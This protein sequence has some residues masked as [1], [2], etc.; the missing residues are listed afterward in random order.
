MNRHFRDTVV[1]Q[2]TGP[3][4]RL[5]SGRG[6]AF[7]LAAAGAAML[8]TAAPGAIAP[9]HAV[10]CVSP[11]TTDTD[12]V[13]EVA[14]GQ[15]CTIN[16]GVQITPATGSNGVVA[17][18]PIDE[19]R[20]INVNGGIVVNGAAVVGVGIGSNT[21]VTVGEW[22]TG[23]DNGIY[24]QGNDVAA[25][26][27]EGNSNTITNAGFMRVERQA[28]AG[29][30]FEPN[31]A[32]KIRGNNNQV[33]NR[34]KIPSDPNDAS[35]VIVAFGG[36]THAI[37]IEGNNN[38]VR[39]D[40]GN[41]VTNGVGSAAIGIDGDTN[42]V[43]NGNPANPART[44]LIETNGR[45]AH[46][47]FM[48]GENN[49]ARNERGARIITRG[50]E[51]H[52][53]FIASTTPPAMRRS[54]NNRLH[55]FGQVQTEGSGAHAMAAEG[56]DNTL[57]NNTG[58][59]ILTSSEGAYA[60]Y[61]DNTADI[62]AAANPDD[63]K[64]NT[65]TNAAKIRTLGVGAHAMAA[66]GDNNKLV[67]NTG[68]E[69]QTIGE[70]AY[71]MYADSTVA[72]AAAANPDDVKGNTLTNAAKIQ[73]LG[74]GAHAMA[75]KG[76]NN[77]LANNAGGEIQTSSEGAY[78][79]WADNRAA[80]GDIKGNTLTNAAKM[81]TRGVNA[82]AMA[83]LGDNNKLAN[84]AGGDILTLNDGAVAM[85]TFGIG[86]ALTNAAK[87]ETRGVGAYAMWAGGN[88][89][90]LANNAGGNILTKGKGAYA[91]AVLGEENILANNAGGEILTI[92]E[93]AHA[94][95][96]VGVHNTLANNARMKTEGDTAS[97]MYVLG[98]TNKLVNTATLIT[99]G[100]FSHGALIIGKD[101]TFE[102]GGLIRVS[103]EDS[104]AISILALTADD[105]NTITLTENSRIEGIVQLSRDVTIAGTDYVA[106]KETVNFYN[107]AGTVVTFDRAGGLPETINTGGRYY[108]AG[109]PGKGN[110]F[111]VVIDPA[112]TIGQEDV[113]LHDLTATISNSIHAQLDAARAASQGV[114]AGLRSSANSA[115]LGA[116]I[117]DDFGD[118]ADPAPAAPM[119]QD[120]FR[121]WGQAFGSYRDTD[122]Q[123][124]RLDATHELYGGIMGFDM[125]LDTAAFSGMRLGA[126]A[127]YSSGDVEVGGGNTG[128]AG[129]HARTLDTDTFFGGVYA[130]Y[131]QD[132]W[133]AR[134]IL[135][136]GVLDNESTRLVFDGLA[137]NGYWL[138]KGSYD[139]MYFSPEVAAGANFAMGGMKLLPSVRLRYAHL[140]L[141]SYTE[142][143]RPSGAAA[144]E[145]TVGKRDVNLFA[146]RAQLAIEKSWGAFA[147][148]PR[149][150][151][152][153]Y[154]SDA[155]NVSISIA[156]G[157][158]LSVSPAGD[159]SEV[160]GFIG[161]RLA[162]TI[163]GSASL[164]AD[165]E[166][167]FGDNGTSRYEGRV[168]AAVRF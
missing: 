94:M 46:A 96:A 28:V 10:P 140:S 50:S 53:M 118:V 70:G 156:Q 49:E 134:M 105:E 62:A 34:R 81:E 12:Q 108:L 117:A 29:T 115:Q 79:M 48:I 154:A 64:G 30:D 22:I 90:T 153:G 159:D 104:F 86:N 4:F 147:V 58:G 11:I 2:I 43:V 124:S 136:L 27:V 73:T 85:Y 66:K 9:A 71:A 165:G 45:E 126:F 16:S 112:Y 133:Y 167:H 38:Q 149:I 15:E 93:G 14:P 116:D 87:M 103:G 6:T 141:D 100:K 3:A 35:G 80:T 127:G 155:D 164:F 82:Y 119:A 42:L 40:F 95:Y 84:N 162:T 75:A 139:G 13:Q 129:N 114:A 151:V 60:M 107:R 51:A 88:K 21:I 76:D 132:V 121:I 1:T 69:I 163:G 54:K 92:E 55:N 77:K 137:P 56:D 128:N 25:I 97:A 158:T 33:V 8:F 144:S 24:V 41:I 67:N 37:G 65:L 146:G 166:V 123:G 101:N 148:T 120:R 125:A 111:V 168:G 72:A 106:A 52:A 91:M 32:I 160:T 78:A 110:P 26:G 74:V 20:T 68:G 18:T 113:Q 145:L 59:E 102:N 98:E 142:T 89:N 131:S 122:P 23:Q 152:E 44:S 19:A 99:T 138:A 31:F 61:A 39:N 36:F 143:G 161:A 5:R 17:A 47:I 109:R 157:N 135:G 150:G 83:A 7:L 130:D 57:A 63:V